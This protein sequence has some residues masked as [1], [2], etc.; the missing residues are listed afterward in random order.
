MISPYLAQQFSGPVSQAIINSAKAQFDKTQFELDYIKNA[1]IDTV[2]TDLLYYIGIW[3]GLPW[4]L[5]PEGTFEEN[6]FWHSQAID[7][8]ETSAL[9]GF[10]AGLLSSTSIVDM[11][12]YPREVYVKLL[13]AWCKLRVE[14]LSLATIELLVSSFSTNYTL[15]YDANKDIVFTFLPNIE[16]SSLFALRWLIP[17]VTT[18][19]S[20]ILAQG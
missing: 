12:Q 1:D 7:Y 11:V 18:S 16:S 6:M 4:P 15:S 2:Q 5:A 8:P 19:P 10:S 17:I 20:V 9:H 3:C 14:G 13:K